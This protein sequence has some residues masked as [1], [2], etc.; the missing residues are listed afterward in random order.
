MNEKTVR[1][2]LENLPIPCIHYFDETDSTNEQALSLLQQEEQPEFS[3]FV[4]A[5][6]TA[7]RG[8]LERSWFSAPGAS[9][10]FSLIIHPN[11]MEQKKVS[12]FSLFGAMGIC[13]AL[14]KNCKASI[15]VKWPN[16]VLL[17]GRKTAGVLV[18]ALWQADNL[19]GLVMGI[20]INVLPASVPRDTELLFP[21]TCVQHHCEGKIQPLLIMRDVLASL[22]KLRLSVS[23]PEFLI[24][25]RQRLAFL[26]QDVSVMHSKCTSHRGELIGVDEFGQLILRL[27]D[28][29]QKTCAI[30]DLSLRPH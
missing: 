17:D 15:K 12:L 23:A 1:Q 27:A 11:P 3:L 25:Y 24:L 19:R 8:R 5:R 16:D 9:L 30:G 6:Q 28:G 7:G 21:A 26:H 22:I 10:T 20:G 4:A 14:E 2:T 13:Q 18:E 29:S